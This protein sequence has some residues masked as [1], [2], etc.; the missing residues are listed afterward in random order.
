MAHRNILLS[1]VPSVNDITGDLYEATT[2]DLNPHLPA[3]TAFVAMIESLRNRDFGVLQQHSLVRLPLSIVGSDHV[4]YRTPMVEM[5]HE[6]ILSLRMSDITIESMRKALQR[7]G[8]CMFFMCSCGV[9]IGRCADIRA[10]Y[11]SDHHR[12]MD[13]LRSAID[14][15]GNP[16]VSVGSFDQIPFQTMDLH[17]N[18]AEERLFFRIEE[19]TKLASVA[20]HRD[21]R[22]IND[23]LSEFVGSA[24]AAR[25]SQKPFVSALAA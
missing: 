1:A 10:Y 9:V 18:G 20:G 22:W 5:L 17:A 8:I 4:R 19:L 24:T 14:A 11:G 13:R 3:F 7:K 12:R 6:S 15:A 21:Y 25:A 2:S 23:E 16:V